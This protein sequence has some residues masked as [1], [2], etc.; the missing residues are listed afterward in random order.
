MGDD[1]MVTPAGWTVSRRDDGRLDVRKGDR[2]FVADAVV[3][4]EVAWVWIDGYLLELPV[5]SAARR[6]AAGGGADAVALTP[7][8]SAKVIRVNVA[9][10]QT[11]SAGDTLVVLE[12]MKMEMPIRA[13]RDGVITAVHCAEGDLVQPG[14][15]LVDY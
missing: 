1:H 6:R 14:Q 10:G 8:M 2:H 4:D 7:Q 5:G 13:P 15:Q 3:Q 11:V 9:A 12:A